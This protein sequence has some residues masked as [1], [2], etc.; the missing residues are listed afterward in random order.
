[1]IKY[2]HVQIKR[3]KCNNKYSNGTKIMHYKNWGPGMPHAYIYILKMSAMFEA[4]HHIFKGS[5]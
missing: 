3:N 2:T 4:R 5:K 1:M